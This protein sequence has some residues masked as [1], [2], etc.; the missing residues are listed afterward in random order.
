MFIVKYFDNFILGSTVGMQRS[1]AALVFLP[2]GMSNATGVGLA[3]V[4]PSEAF[5][6]GRWR[7][8]CVRVTVIYI[9]GWN[10]HSHPETADV[11]E[12]G[13]PLTGGDV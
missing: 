8:H 10:R 3:F 13:E 9:G 7:R 11:N 2:R 6:S 12:E 4:L 5:R 1:D